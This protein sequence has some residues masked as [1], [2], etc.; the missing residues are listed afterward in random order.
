MKKVY[1]LC[2]N[3]LSGMN[4][5]QCRNGNR[6]VRNN[7]QVA[8]SR[9][10]KRSLYQHLTTGPVLTAPGPPTTCV[11]TRPYRRP[12]VPLA[13][14]CS[15]L[16]SGS[17]KISR[18]SGCDRSGFFPAGTGTSRGKIWPGSGCSRKFPR[19]K[20]AR[21]GLHQSN[22]QGTLRQLCDS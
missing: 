3:F 21:A 22:N 19:P 13:R 18:D 10:S 20:L 8:G 4:L 17:R 14:Q 9:G 2:S 6:D 12:S 16:F 11:P 15:G 1:G 7:H 5:R